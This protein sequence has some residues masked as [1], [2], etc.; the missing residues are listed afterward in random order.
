MRAVCAAFGALIVALC[1][2]SASA[3]RLSSLGDLTS[4]LTIHTHPFPIATVAGAGTVAADSAVT[5]PKA[6]KPKR[7][8]EYKVMPG[9]TARE[10]FTS[11]LPHTY[12]KKHKLPKNFV[13][14]NVS[15]VNYLTKNLNQHI[16][17][18]CGSCWVGPVVLRAMPLPPFHP[19][20]PHAVV[21]PRSHASHQPLT[22]V[23]VY[24]A[25][26]DWWLFR[27]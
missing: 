24:L 12:V 14:S 5:T 15:G 26:V 11:P 16:P 9:H 7:F 17:Q 27:F 22:S 25:L 23:L 3:A 21:L 6:V 4:P 2:S 19:R 20:A 8:N 18:Y 13:W 10:A 1:A